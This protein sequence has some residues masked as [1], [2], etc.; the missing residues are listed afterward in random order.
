MNQ[1]RLDKAVNF[2]DRW[3]EHRYRKNEWP[4]FVVAISNNGKMVFNKAYGYANLEKKEKLTVNHIFRTASHS[5]TFTA[6]AT[7]CGP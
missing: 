5:K 7:V 2:I 4:G 3:M 1:L 6:T